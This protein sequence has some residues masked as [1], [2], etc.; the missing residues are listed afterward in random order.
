MNKCIAYDLKISLLG[1]FSV[2]TLPP[3]GW[4]TGTRVSAAELFNSETWG[5]NPQ[6]YF[7]REKEN[8][9]P[10]VVTK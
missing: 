8:Y 6:M 1:K 10:F 4:D 7:D 5:G 2:K 9:F 3:V